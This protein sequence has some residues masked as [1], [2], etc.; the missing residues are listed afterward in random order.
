MKTDVTASEKQC[1]GKNTIYINFFLFEI[2]LFSLTV[3]KIQHVLV[4]YNQSPLASIFH[5]LASGGF[6]KLIPCMFNSALVILKEFLLS[7]TGLR[8]I[9][10]FPPPI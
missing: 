7:A 2:S 1:L 8:L 3:S 5:N 6:F 10:K 4:S 9:L